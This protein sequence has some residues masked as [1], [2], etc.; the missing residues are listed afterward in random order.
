MQ[1]G[2]AGASFLCQDQILVARDLQLKISQM[3]ANDTD[4]NNLDTVLA[5]FERSHS[6]CFR[7]AVS[8]SGRT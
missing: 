3:S 1:S 6:R 5:L 2:G 4:L 8:N 7:G